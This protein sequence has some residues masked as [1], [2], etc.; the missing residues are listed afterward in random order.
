MMTRKNDTFSSYVALDDVA[1]FEE[2]QLDGIAHLADTW[3]DNLHPEVSAQLVQ[4][5]AQ[6]LPLL[7][8]GERYSQRQ[9]QG[10]D[11][12]FARQI[13]HWRTDEDD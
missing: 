12:L 8:K 13:C 1:V 4:A 11:I 3:D 10:A 7:R 9:G 5:S 2:A 6:S